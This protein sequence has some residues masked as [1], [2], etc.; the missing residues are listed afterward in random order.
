MICPRCKGTKR[1]RRSFLGLFSWEAPCPLCSQMTEIYPDYDRDHTT[2]TPSAGSPPQASSPGPSPG[3]SPG[4]APGG[5]TAGGAGASASWDEAQSGETAGHRGNS[6]PPLI[7]DPF[8]AESADRGT[9]PPADAASSP[10]AAE[11]A[12]SDDGS[13][14]Y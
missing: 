13:T 4:M 14:A 8:A 12:A 6:E 11:G 2:F 3:P 7:V 5:G 1:V 10:A 9:E